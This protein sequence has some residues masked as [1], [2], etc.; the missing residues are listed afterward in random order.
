MSKIN[1]LIEQISTFKTKK[2]LEKFHAK[3]IQPILEIYQEDFNE[4]KID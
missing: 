1:D 4:E 2:S 3:Y